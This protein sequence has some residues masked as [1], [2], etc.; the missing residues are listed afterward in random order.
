[1]EHTYSLGEVQKPFAIMPKG[2]E[3]YG[4]AYKFGGVEGAMPNFMLGSCCDSCSKSGGSCGGLGG[5]NLSGKNLLLYGGV[6][7]AF[8]LGQKYAKNSM[9]FSELNALYND[10]LGSYARKK[11]AKQGLAAAAGLGVAHILGKL[12]PGH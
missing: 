5:I 6:I 8:V 7:A 1:M 10:V 12:M 2:P 9:P 3:A 11:Y 4:L